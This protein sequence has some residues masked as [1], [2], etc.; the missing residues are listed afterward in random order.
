METIWEILKNVMLVCI[1]VM[2]SNTQSCFYF[3]IFY[4][5]YLSNMKYRCDRAGTGITT[6]GRESK[7][8]VPVYLASC[9]KKAILN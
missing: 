2:Y 9:F 7:L 3:Q 4:L 6:M 5:Q 1:L 8:N